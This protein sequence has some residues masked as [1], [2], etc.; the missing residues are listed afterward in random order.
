MQEFM[1][2]NK[3]FLFSVNSMNF[4]IFSQSVKTQFFDYKTS[5][6]ALQGICNITGYDSYWK[7]VEVALF[8]RRSPN[9]SLHPDFFHLL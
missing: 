9:A 7:F 2:S 8:K 6:I 5:V 3:Y 1:S 4:Q